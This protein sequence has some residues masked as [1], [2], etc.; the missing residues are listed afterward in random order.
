V[1]PAHGDHDYVRHGTT[2]GSGRCLPAPSTGPGSIFDPGPSRKRG[3]GNR[4]IGEVSIPALGS[5]IVRGQV[6]QP[7]LTERANV[8]G[9]FRARVRVVSRG[10][11]SLG[12]LD[13]YMER[14]TWTPAGFAATLADA[15]I[16]IGP[17]P[18]NDYARGKCA[19]KLLQYGASGLRM[20]GS[21]VCANALA[22]SL[23]GGVPAGSASE[24]TDGISSLLEESETQL[25]ARGIGA[26][27]AAI[28]HYSF[29]TWESAWRAAMRIA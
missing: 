26:R 10:A 1:I 8:C 13:P 15:D 12:P 16:G 20:V 3:Q 6:P 7:R 18:D 24:W 25:L 17:L 28:D 2:S 4:H 9:R 22:L 19:Y 27:Q 5:L 14:I 11:N 23:M 21:P 29:Q